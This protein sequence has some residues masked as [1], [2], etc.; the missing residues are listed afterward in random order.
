[1]WL[2]VSFPCESEFV[3]GS[4]QFA[5]PVTST[6]AGSTIKVVMSSLAD[7]YKSVSG[8]L[9]RALSTQ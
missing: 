4:C 2:V 5:V 3:C 9:W 6:V 8:F 1:M 7:V